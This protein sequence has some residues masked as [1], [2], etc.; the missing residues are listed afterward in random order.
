MHSETR[1]RR[2]LLRAAGGLAVGGAALASADPAR[3]QETTFGGWLDGVGNYDGVADER[4]ASE[5]TVEVGSQ[6]NGGSFG[7]SPPAVRVDPETTVTWEWVAGNHNVVDDAGGF[8]SELTSEEGFTFSQTFEETG[9]VK[10]YCN[11]HKPM[12]MRGV[13]IVGD[14]PAQALASESATPTA[15]QQGPGNA[16]ATSAGGRDPLS[17]DEWATVGSALTVVVGLLSPLAYATFRKDS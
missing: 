9:L 15:A 4:G 14:E 12:G 11:P 17:G 8:E 13:V 7:F 6:A 5:I 2:E 16:T 10:Y 1:T 3:A